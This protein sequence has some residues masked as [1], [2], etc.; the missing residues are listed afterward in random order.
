MRKSI[1][2]LSVAAALLVPGLAAAQA[3]APSPFTGNATL[4]TDY[5]FRGISQTFGKWAFQGGFDYA[6]ASGF[7]AG[8]WNSNVSSAAGYPGGNLEMDF[9]GGYKRAFGDFGIDAGLLY[10]YYPGTDARLLGTRNGKTNSGTV[11]NTEGYLAGSWK[12]ITLKWSHAFSDYFQTP[13]TK[14]TNYLDLG[15]AYD[16]GGGWGVNGHIGHTSVHNFGAASYSDYKLGV[17]KDLSGW[18]LGASLISTN[19]K[20]NCPSDPYCFTKPT[21]TTPSYDA[22]K[23]T[24]VFSVGKT[25]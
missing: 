5:R 11:Y 21:G 22:G 19:A 6:H 18:L 24:I 2:S 20:H 12:W 9:Y 7:Y 15:A 14:G 17:T 10:Y 13:D 3:A 1:L 16:A 4:I 25:F 23:S 8:N